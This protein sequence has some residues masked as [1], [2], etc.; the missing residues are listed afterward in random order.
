M[1]ELKQPRPK[2]YPAHAPKR[3]YPGDSGWKKTPLSATP[4]AEPPANMVIGGDWRIVLN[5]NFSTSN[6]DMQRWWTR[7]IYQDGYL[8]YL[9]DEWERFR[10]DGN[11]VLDG[12]MCHLT[13]LPH[14]GEFWPSGML[15]SKD[16]FD[17]G[18]GS[19]WYF[20]E[21]AKSPAG[22][23]VWPGFWLAGCER[24]P[25]DDGS[26]YWPPE[27]D[28]MEIVNNGNAGEDTTSLHCGGIGWDEWQGNTWTWTDDT[29]NGQWSFWQAPFDFAAGF[30]T[31]GLFYCRPNYVIYCDRKPVL[32]GTYNWNDWQ[33]PVPGCHVQTQLSIGGGWAGRNGVDDSAM[34]QSLDVD[35][36]RV[37]TRVCQSTIGHDLLPV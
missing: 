18:N 15:R 4:R 22:L 30:H 11:H 23:G 37:Y 16:L 9:N 31:F 29:F 7:F 35:Y 32:A 1:P 8:D 3:I 25:G 26:C 10:E 34:P 17:V 36:I 5:E 6:I 28:I 14:N 13:A 24:E 19:E 20:E 33:G 2:D 21:R 27:I 12:S